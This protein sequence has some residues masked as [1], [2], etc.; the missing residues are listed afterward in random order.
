[1]TNIVIS[2]S[3]RGWGPSRDHAST[4]FNKRSANCSAPQALF[5]LNKGGQCRFSKRLPS[6]ILRFQEA[7]RVKQKPVPYL[8]R[9]LAF[10]VWL[11]RSH[12]EEKPGFFELLQCLSATS[13]Q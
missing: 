4:S 3:C 8:E 9:E 12:S 13:P 7:I 10:G 5:F 11:I 2:S 1:M 6:C